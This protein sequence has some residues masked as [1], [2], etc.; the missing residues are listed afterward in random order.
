LLAFIATKG[1]KVITDGYLSKDDFVF[2]AQLA[3]TA[4]LKERRQNSVWTN[5]VLAGHLCT[6]YLLLKKHDDLY[7]I[8]DR[9]KL[10][11]RQL[12]TRQLVMVLLP[13]Q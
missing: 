6:Y 3:S 12:P 1:K 10:I 7:E 4:K 5:S 13:L 8:F 9:I 11:M 2:F